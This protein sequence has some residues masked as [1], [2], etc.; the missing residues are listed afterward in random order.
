[1]KTYSKNHFEL[2]HVSPMVRDLVL[3]ALSGLIVAV[4]VMAVIAML[5][6]RY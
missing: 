2:W 1:M 6:S 3:V 4:S 5:A